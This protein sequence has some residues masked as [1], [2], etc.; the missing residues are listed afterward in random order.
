MGN[1]Q[2]EHQRSRVSFRDKSAPYLDAISYDEPYNRKLF[3]CPNCH[4][5]FIEINRG[6]PTEVSC[7][8]CN[9]KYSI[10]FFGSQEDCYG[11]FVRQYRNQKWNS[12]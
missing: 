8:N 6:S 4:G 10:D 11:E 1:K 7:R 12:L 9:L 2:D 5:D 3:Q